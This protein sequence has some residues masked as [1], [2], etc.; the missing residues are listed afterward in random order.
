MPGSAHPIRANEPSS[1]TQSFRKPLLIYLV[2]VVVMLF[3]ATSPFTVG[4]LVAILTD[5]VMQG[6]H[7]ITSWTAEAPLKSWLLA[8]SLGLVVISACVLWFFFE[9]VIVKRPVLCAGL[10]IALFS[11]V[12]VLE[13][14]FICL[15]GFEQ[16]FDAFGT[17]GGTPAWLNAVATFVVVAFANACHVVVAIVVLGAMFFATPGY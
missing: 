16:L 15:P 9:E 6:H 3:L 7:A 13:Y 17:A 11:C 1:T 5:L 4:P 12:V 14:L 2:F 10:L 8:G